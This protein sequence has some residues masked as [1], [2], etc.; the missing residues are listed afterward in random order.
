DTVSNAIFREMQQ[1]GR[2]CVYLDCRHLDIRTFREHFPNIIKQCRFFGIDV[3]KDLIPVAPAAHYQCGGIEVNRRA[4]TSVKNLYANGERAHTGLH[5]ANRL[6]SNSLLEAVVFA[7][8][9]ACTAAK[10][11]DNIALQK[12]ISK[13]KSIYIG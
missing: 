9:A 11:L 8:E 3:F 4:Q 2:H 10:E 13:E 7:H 5:G 1:S 6:A 12:N